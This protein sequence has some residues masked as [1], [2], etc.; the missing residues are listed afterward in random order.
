MHNWYREIEITK[1][2]KH[3]RNNYVQLYSI[4]KK[5]IKRLYILENH[6]KL[7]VD[8]IPNRKRAFHVQ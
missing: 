1:A 6:M 4:K 2:F 7:T 3:F 5:Q 8:E